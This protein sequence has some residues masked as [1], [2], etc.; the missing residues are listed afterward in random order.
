MITTRTF[1]GEKVVYGAWIARE[2]RL[3]VPG[4]ELLTLYK[5]IIENDSRYMRP[6]HG[7]LPQITI[8]Y[9][10]HEAVAVCALY[11][12]TEVHSFCKVSHRRMGYATAALKA[13]H[14]HKSRHGYNP[15]G[16]ASEFW[17]ANKIDH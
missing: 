9:D 14:P 2:A 13:A 11:H 10:G 1:K 3:Y 4:W 6:W 15:T 12:Q 7:K 16:G 5:G 17:R 8:A